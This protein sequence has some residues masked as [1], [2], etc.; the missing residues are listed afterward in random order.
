MRLSFEF[1]KITP[2]TGNGRVYFGLGTFVHYS[3]GIHLPFSSSDD[4]RVNDMNVFF[5]KSVS[6]L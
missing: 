2:G 1:W 6:T 5:F 3:V 4:I